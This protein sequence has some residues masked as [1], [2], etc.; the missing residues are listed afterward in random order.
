[1][2]IYWSST[3]IWDMKDRFYVEVYSILIEHFVLA[4]V[5]LC[6]F[7]FSHSCMQPCHHRHPHHQPRH[8][9]WQLWVLW[10]LNM[11]RILIHLATFYIYFIV[12][13]G[14]GVGCVS[15][16]LFYYGGLKKLHG[17]CYWNVSDETITCSVFWWFSVIYDKIYHQGFLVFCSVIQRNHSELQQ[18]FSLASTTELQ[19]R[20]S[21]V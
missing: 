8:S 1:M 3:K 13:N 5:S 19:W 10:Q 17:L 12:N 21:H 4:Q 15:L 14:L 20:P 7:K 6:W 2:E 18:L 16:S 9:P 11:W